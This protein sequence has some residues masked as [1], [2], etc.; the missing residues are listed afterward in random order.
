MQNKRFCFQSRFI[1]SYF[2]KLVMNA[3]IIQ[4]L[5]LS[6]FVWQTIWRLEEQ[7]MRKRYRKRTKNEV[8]CFQISSFYDLS[9][10]SRR[11]ALKETGKFCNVSGNDAAMDMIRKN[12]Y[13][14]KFYPDGTIYDGY[15]DD[16]QLESSVYVFWYFFLKQ[17]VKEEKDCLFFNILYMKNDFVI[18]YHICSRSIKN[19][20]KN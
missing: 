1:I 19:K 20:N 17:T 15:V 12:R 4:N 3:K 2:W 7:L 10:D 5:H 13:F 16:T 9:L 8:K 11:T 6:Y 18:F 14:F